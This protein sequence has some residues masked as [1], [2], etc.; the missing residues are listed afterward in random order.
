M[1]YRQGIQQQQHA[2]LLS[3]RHTQQEVGHEGAAARQGGAAAQAGAERRALQGQKGGTGPARGAGIKGE[4]RKQGGDSEKG[5][6]RKHGRGGAPWAQHRSVEVVH[7]EHAQW[8]RKQPAARSGCPG[9]QTPDQLAPALPA[10]QLSR[11]GRVCR[12][13]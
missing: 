3:S 5:I 7:W 10:P 13:A 12:S 11:G 2:E 9:H 8:A 6:L 4:Q 1:A